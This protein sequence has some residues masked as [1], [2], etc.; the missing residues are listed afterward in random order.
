MTNFIVYMI[1][2]VLVVAALAYGASLL[3]ISRSWITVG[4]VA[5]L[6]LGVMGGIVKTRQRD[7]AQ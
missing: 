5:L 4:V 3:G 2:M 1:G 7:P 6:G